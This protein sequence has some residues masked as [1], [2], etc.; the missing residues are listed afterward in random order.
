MYVHSVPTTDCRA[1]NSTAPL[2]R[3]KSH[4][5]ISVLAVA[6]RRQKTGMYLHSGQKRRDGA[7]PSNIATAWYV[8]QTVPPG[9]IKQHNSIPQASTYSSFGSAQYDV[10][11]GAEIRHWTT[12]PRDWVANPEKRVHLQAVMRVIES[13]SRIGGKRMCGQSPSLCSSIPGR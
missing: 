12:R 5:S 9:A 13:M 11:S 3:C 7:P 6:L 8:A 1:C 2:P 10:Q 4:P